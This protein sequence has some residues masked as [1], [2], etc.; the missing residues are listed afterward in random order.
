[1]KQKKILLT[2]IFILIAILIS[3]ESEFSQN[4][5]F[6][7]EENGSIDVYFCPENDCS[8]KIL[9]EILISEKIICAF[10]DLSD[11]DLIDALKQKKADVIIDEDNFE[12]FGIPI[13]KSGLMH[14]KFCVLDDK[15]IITGSYN[16]TQ[17][18]LN[19]NN[20]LIIESVNLANNYEKE[21]FRIKNGLK[22]SNDATNKILFNN[23]ELEQYF[24]PK[25]DCQEKIIEELSKA[26]YS[27]QF[28]AFT[29]TD[30][31]I[32]QKILSKHEE[33]KHVIGLIDEFQ[34][35]KYWVYPELNNS[36]ITIYLDDKKTIQHNK[37]FVI[38]NKTVITGS[39][40]PTIAA[41]TKNDENII[42]ITQPDVV[43][44]Y[45]NYLNALLTLSDQKLGKSLSVNPT[46]ES[47]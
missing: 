42:I 8:S 30:K 22:D 36:G 26:E 13:H 33:G 37:I 28:L 14:N 45:V 23:Y 43:S 3:V 20:L 7:V 17:N 18:N 35:K 25:D 15:K 44:K 32:S 24:C 47:E 41:N 29:F 34:N 46:N 16:P 1:M 39:Y 6:V 5:N 40:N 27:I 4:N 12:D 38:D 2:V 19:N 11:E 31:K 10:Y 21:F 9:N